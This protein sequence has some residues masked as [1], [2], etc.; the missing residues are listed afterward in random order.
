MDIFILLLITIFIIWARKKRKKPQYNLLYKNNQPYNNQ[1]A[2]E[3]INTDNI[4]DEPINEENNYPTQEELD[5]L[6]FNGIKDRWSVIYG[7][8]PNLFNLMFEWIPNGEYKQILR[9]KQFRTQKNNYAP[10]FT[11]FNDG[12]SFFYNSYD[13]LGFKVSLYGYVQIEYPCKKCFV[14]ILI[15]TFDKNIENDK[16]TIE[17]FTDVLEIDYSPETIQNQMQLIKE[18]NE[19]IKKEKERE[20]IEEIK[21]RLLKKKRK[22][23]LEKLALRELMD[24]GVLFPEAGKR[25]PI[26]KDVVDAVWRRDGGKCVYCGS[27][28][29]L[30][31]DHIIPFSKGGATTV[32]NLQL[33]CQKCNLQKSNKIG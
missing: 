24:E 7:I 4:N 1:S 29:N 3:I 2:N 26:P 20:E 9:F 15:P 27:T 8:N 31:L 19:R 25:P 11:D 21:K 6:A 22:E 13:H 32:E 17:D 16:K 30:Q 10:Y 18:E 33:L 5:K 14:K 28:E 12:K 23:D